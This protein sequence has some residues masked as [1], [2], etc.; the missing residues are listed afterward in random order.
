MD[1]SEKRGNTWNESREYFDPITL[2]KMRQITQHGIY[3]N[4]MGYHTGIGWSGDGENILLIMGRNDLSA[5]V[6]CHVPTGE[7]KQITDAYH[8]LAIGPRPGHTAGN[9][10]KKRKAV[11]YHHQESRTVRIVDVDTLE[12]EIVAEDLDRMGPVSADE[13]F[14]LLTETGPEGEPG[15]NEA[16]ERPYR[17]LKCSLTDGSR[18]VVCEGVGVA[19]HIQPSPV[20]SDLVL[21][22]RNTPLYDYPMFGVT[23]RTWLLRLSTGELTELAPRNDNHA[24]WHAT[25]RWDGKYIFYHGYSGPRANWVKPCQDGW[26]VGAIDT[27]GNVH[28]EYSSPGWTNYG[29]VGSLGSRDV[30]LLDGNVTNN[31]ILALHF[32]E[33]EKPHFEMVARHNTFWTSNYGQMCHPHTVSDQ[34]GKYVAFNSLDRNKVGPDVFVV[35]Y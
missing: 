29:H 34:S 24:E 25:W 33:E 23:N 14:F 1:L 21:L 13:S 12:D 4:T 22:D 6:N 20:D 9:Y 7:L 27:S 26:Y 5:L 11:I 8:G 15:I 31:M 2:R 16:Y 28:R 3:N 30:I 32:E 10:L 18:E 17:F 35:E 19:G